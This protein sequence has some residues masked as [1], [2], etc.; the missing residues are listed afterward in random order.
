M[1][2]RRLS[3]PATIEANHHVLYSELTFD[4]T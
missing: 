3:R 1:L 2:E 4:T